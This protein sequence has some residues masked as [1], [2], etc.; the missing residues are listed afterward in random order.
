MEGEGV[1]APLYLSVKRE[2][3]DSSVIIA[4][5]SYDYLNSG[6]ILSS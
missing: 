3:L 1:R 5:F 2:P 4:Q 6:T